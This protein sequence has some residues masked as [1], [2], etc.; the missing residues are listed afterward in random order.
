VRVLFLTN[1]PNL[2]STSRILQ[3]WLKLGVERGLQ[4]HVVLQQ[5]G[6]FAAWLAANGFPHLVDP[7][8]WPDRRWP[9]PSLWHAWRVARWA[10][11]RGVEIIH[12]NEHDVFP[13]ALLL[14]RLLA[15][16]IVCH[17][18]F[19]VTR[20][21]AEWIFRGKT[22]RPDA[23]LWTSFRQKEDC[24]AAVADIVPD[25]RQY[26]VRLG[27][28]TGQF[29]TMGDSRDSTR[30]AWG[31]ARHE[32]VIGTASPLRPRK[33]IEDFVELIV[34][35]ARS[36]ADI[37]GVIAG[38]TIDGDEAYADQ[39]VRKIESTG[40][41]RKLQWL[42]N[43]EPVEPFYHACDIV[44][45][46]SEYET[47]GNSVCEAMACGK[48][49]AAYSGGSVREVADDAGLIVETGDLNGLTAAVSRLLSDPGLRRQL[50]SRGRARL[51]EQF[52]P[53]KS[54]EQLLQI[55]ESLLPSDPA[56]SNGHKQVGDPIHVAE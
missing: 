15:C 26:V 8:P 52:S 50:G 40:L 32:I 39:I 30:D 54:L 42:G 20:E 44:V 13:F 27:L 37:A 3:S 45:S 12:C 16:P 9:V 6:D 17:V 35:L 41:G 24:A 11:Q 53:A 18:R 25:D 43:M 14:R 36:H 4:G 10:R 48:P 5:K 1:N 49:V 47:F 34:Q 56:R 28:D 7:M 2:C 51:A 22:R 29:G 23:L 31:V 33:R 55:Y 19:I 46:T 21:F 38:G